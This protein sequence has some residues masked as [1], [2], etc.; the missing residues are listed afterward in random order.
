LVILLLG[1][2]TKHAAPRLISVRAAQ[3]GAGGTSVTL[4]LGNYTANKPLTL[5][6]T[7]LTGTGGVAIATI[8]TKL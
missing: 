6:A 3:P 2:P 5:T 7:G 4:L 1:G 8:F